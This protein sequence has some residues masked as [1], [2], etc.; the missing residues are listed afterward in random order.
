LRSHDRAQGRPDL[1][2]AVG[3]DH[4]VV[5]EHVEQ[6]REVPGG[7]CHQEAVRQLSAVAEVRIEALAAPLDVPTGT[8]SKLPAGGGRPPERPGHL[9][10]R[11]AEDVMEEI[12]GA[13]EGRELLEEHEKRK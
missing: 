5:R 12:C 10:E 8:S 1:A 6:A 3:P 9:L 7:A 13:L 2:P 11:I 4:D